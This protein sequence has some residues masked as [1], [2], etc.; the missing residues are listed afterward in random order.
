MKNIYLKLIGVG[1]LVISLAS[2][3]AYVDD[4]YAYPQAHH[5]V[6][7]YTYYDDRG[8]AW[9]NQHWVHRHHH[10]AP[11]YP[12]HHVVVIHT[13]EHKHHHSK[14]SST[15]YG[16]SYKEVVEKGDGTHFGAPAR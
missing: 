7:T 4:P 16:T 2:C 11:Y 12:H 8:D 5:D 10:P 15:H 1:V 13:D 9:P 14:G 6:T 3:T